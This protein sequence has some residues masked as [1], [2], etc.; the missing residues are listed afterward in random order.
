M[1]EYVGGFLPVNSTRTPTD[2]YI[3]LHAYKNCAC[4]VSALFL[5]H[6]CQSISLRKNIMLDAVPVG[7][8]ICTRSC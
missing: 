3:L 4:E 6:V 2:R 1:L 5:S 7:G 8:A